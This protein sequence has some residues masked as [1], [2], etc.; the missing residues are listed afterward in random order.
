MSENGNKL[1]EQLVSDLVE[2]TPSVDRKLVRAFVF[3]GLFQLVSRAQTLWMPAIMNRK[4]T[5]FLS[6]FFTIAD[7]GGGKGE[8]KKLAK[9]VFN[10]YYKEFSKQV[11]EKTDS[12]NRDVTSLAKAK[13][14]F[15]NESISKKE[16]T[17]LVNQANDFI[18]KNRVNGFTKMN[19]TFGSIQGVAHSLNTMKEVKIGSYCHHIDECASVIISQ[20]TATQE[21]LTTL[22]SFSGGVDEVGRSLAREVINL[23]AEGVGFNLHLFGNME[24]FLTT[25]SSQKFISFL[26]KGFARRCFFTNIKE[27][28]DVTV[29]DVL[30]SPNYSS[31][32]KWDKFFLEKYNELRGNEAFYFNFSEDARKFVAEIYVDSRVKTSNR[33]AD[34]ERGDHSLK[35]QTLSCMLAMIDG[36][37]IVDKRHCEEAYFYVKESAKDYLTLMGQV[38][39]DLLSA[40]E[41]WCFQIAKL[42]KTTD[43]PLAKKLLCGKLKPQI[44][45]KISENEW[46]EL[47]EQ[48]DKAL[49]E[50]DFYLHRE[51]TANRRGENYMA[52]KLQRAEDIPVS[53]SLC[54]KVV[55]ETEDGVKVFDM[56][57][58]YEW[59]EPQE[60]DNCKLQDAISYTTCGNYSAGQFKDQHRTAKNWLG[61]N[62]MLIYD[63]DAGMEIVEAQSMLLDTACAIMPTKSHQKEKNGV[64]CDR[65][66]VFMPLSTPMDFTDEKRFKRIM[67][68]V[69]ETF[70]L[71]FDKATLDPSRMFYP[72]SIEALEQCWYSQAGGRFVDWKMFDFE[73]L[74]DENLRT[75]AFYHNAT[76]NF[77]GSS[78]ETVERGIRKFFLNKYADGNRNHTIFRA[79]RWCKDKGFSQDEAVGFIKELSA[80]NPLPASEF[81]TTLRSAWR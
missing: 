65:F 48:A 39:D 41:L 25:T 19:T 67:K 64:V 32:K 30:A 2:V 62:T 53:L 68:N 51:P 28:I 34:F 22:L 21:F 37:L 58:P 45:G 20:T 61:G 42:L 1:I 11:D 69:A 78:K 77:K 81:E 80:S 13:F 52:M 36:A 29:D 3:D 57:S 44:R 9:E 54:S 50:E 60:G 5:A 73:S 18:A 72:A 46:E 71:P 7:S 17:N 8:A 16:K 10:S 14:D 31:L 74:N 59:I 27:K 56:A 76:Y 55:G 23:D 49:K 12:Y 79:L 66:R 38:E 43:K 4:K 75:I 24:D 33:E 15:D 70:K 26:R 47:L 6:T 63:I 35:T 40:S